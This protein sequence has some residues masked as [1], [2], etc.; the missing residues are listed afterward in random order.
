MCGGEFL[1]RFVCVEA[2]IRKMLLGN[3]SPM[4]NKTG[5]ILEWNSLIKS[6]TLE[7]F[8]LSLL[9]LL[10]S[11]PKITLEV[12]LFIIPSSLSCVD[13][14]LVQWWNIPSCFLGSWFPV[15]WPF[16]F[17]S[18]SHEMFRFINSLILGLSPFSTISNHMS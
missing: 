6:F 9:H 13:S 5:K 8:F 15:V 2:I 7:H 14:S 11:P 12:L 18:G 4:Y 3:F 10:F 16:E 1:W 17:C